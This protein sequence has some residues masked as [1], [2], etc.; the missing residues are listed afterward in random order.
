MDDAS[1]EKV[2]KAE[3]QIESSVYF[4]LALYLITSYI[5]LSVYERIKPANDF[6]K[7]RAYIN[8]AT[9]A[10]ND[11][12]LVVKK[13]ITEELIDSAKLSIN[14][15]L[16]KKFGYKLDWAMLPDQ[17]SRKLIIPINNK[18][19]FSDNITVGNILDTLGKRANVLTLYKINCK[20]DKLSDN[21]ENGYTYYNTTGI[22]RKSNNNTDSLII[23][24]RIGYGPTRNNYLG[25][26]SE[27]TSIRFGPQFKIRC[28]CENHKSLA[29][30]KY[31]NEWIE[32]ELPWISN[33]LNDIVNKKILNYN[34]QWEASLSKDILEQEQDIAGI[35][36]RN[37]NL[38]LILI[39]S[40]IIVFIYHLALLYSL[41]I[42]DNDTANNLS[43]AI[44]LNNKW[45]FLLRFIIWIALPALSLII[46]SIFISKNNY[47]ILWLIPILFFGIII[48]IR[49]HRI[50][51]T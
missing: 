7:L 42:H 1:K 17:D 34:N 9:Q 51:K 32:S 46:S 44:L 20:P 28:S 22:I 5:S 47:F 48:L 49:I 6:N 27:S 16:N 41:P 8:Y 14:D 25:R 50:I 11:F 18:F 40:A 37:F 29:F 43:L 35:K 21:Q 19:N 4:I 39:A 45:S 23:N 13:R 10:P 31:S 2:E 15:V 24:V 12:V 36:M 3:K 26:S 30:Y 33:N 38:T